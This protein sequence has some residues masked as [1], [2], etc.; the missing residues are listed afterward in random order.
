VTV[1]TYPNQKPWITSNICA[2]LKGR[3]NAFKERDSNPE[4]SKKSHYALWWTIK[5]VTCQYR[6]KIKSYYTSC[7]AHWMWQGLQTISDYKGKHSWKLPSD[8]SLPDELKNTEICM[9][10]SAAPDDCVIMLSAADVRP[11]NMS[12]FTTPQGQTDYQDVY[13]EHVLTNWQ[14][15]HWH[16]QRLSESVI[17]A[18]FKQTTIVPVPKNTKAT[19]L[20]DYR[21]VALMF[22]ATK[23]FER[24]VMA[25]INTIIP[26]TL[27][28]R[29]SSTDDAISIAL[30]T[31]LSHLNKRNC[32]RKLFIDYTDSPTTTRQTIRWCRVVQGQ[33]PSRQVHC[34]SSDTLVQLASGL[35]ARCVKNQCGLVGLC[36]G[37]HMAF[38]LRLSWARTGVVA[39]R[40]D[41]NY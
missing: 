19:C 22:V 32:V 20:N 35:D 3:A 30:H 25:H 23:C 12:T 24:L 21:P 16:F 13:S 5:Q 14:V 6:T 11:L 26:E 34:V 36:F 39:M 33:Q 28:P 27:D 40:Q 9:R 7:E 37:G 15:I 38:D 8:T 41:S 10:A 4:V 2:T 31:A 17:P 29:Q 18:C 1:C